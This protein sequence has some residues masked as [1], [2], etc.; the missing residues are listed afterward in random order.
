MIKRFV[1]IRLKLTFCLVQLSICI[2]VPAVSESIPH[3]AA[4]VIIRNVVVECN[5][6]DCLQ[7]PLETKIMAS[8]NIK[9]IPSDKQQ[10]RCKYIKTIYQQ[11]YTLKE[12]KNLRESTT[13]IV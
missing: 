4:N 6:L 7:P 5:S 8:K 2:Y 9:N 13:Q 11:K 10:R 1:K 3:F 12:K